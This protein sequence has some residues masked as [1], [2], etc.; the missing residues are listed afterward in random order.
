MKG[1]SKVIESLQE[2]LTME[3]SGINQYFIHAK[4]CQNWGYERLAEKI[5]QESISEMKHAELVI[6]RILHL[7]GVPNL[8]RLD[9]IRIGEKVSDQLKA[10]LELEV[11][12]ITRFNKAIALAVEAG[13]NGSR[14]MLE[15]MLVS[16]EDHLQWLESQLELISQVG[17]P[18]YLAQQIYKQQ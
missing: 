13:D 12:A 11:A 1:N 6:D 7:E 4:L 17:E 2:I 9:K 8:Q 15:A 16:E 10:D 18:N 5:R 14:E 3:L